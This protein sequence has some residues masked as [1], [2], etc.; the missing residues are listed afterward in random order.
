MANQ[1]TTRA[2]RRNTYDLGL[3]YCALLVMLL[4]LPLGNVIRNLN[5]SLIFQG[6]R[7]VVYIL[8]V[9][10]ITVYI[11]LTRKQNKFILFF[12]ILLYLLF[13]LHFVLSNYPFLTTL[14]FRDTIKYINILPIAYYFA[15][16]SPSSINKLI[17]VFYKVLVLTAVI[18]IILYFCDLDYVVRSIALKSGV[19]EKGPDYKLIGDFVIRR[20]DPYFG[21]G[22]SGLGIMMALAIVIYYSKITTHRKIG[23]FD[24][25]GFLVVCFTFFGAMSFSGLIALM[26]GV[27][28]VQR[29][30]VLTPKT[31]AWIIPLIVG[32]YLLNVD[33]GIQQADGNVDL[34]AYLKTFF[35]RYEWVIRQLF[36]SPI[37]LLIG[38]GPGIVGNKLTSGL[39]LQV[40]NAPIILG[41]VDGGVFEFGQQFGLP[42]FVFYGVLVIGLFARTRRVFLHTNAYEAKVLA[43]MFLVCLLQVHVPPWIRPGFDVV[44]WMLMGLVAGYLDRV[45]SLPLL[46]PTTHR[47]TVIP[48]FKS[49][50]QRLRQMATSS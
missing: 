4:T 44:F 46:S 42:H 22:P 6:W 29:S 20:M 25:V 24:H 43:I 10:P 14:G 27:L 1:T 15:R 17:N 32:I 28:F 8:L 33:L 39:D 19:I 50:D 9:S 31:L 34:L 12:F 45:Y 23:L 37:N 41:G 30:F 11:L 26:V 35:G 47:E 49:G 7:E 38:I 36:G 13:F 2:I 5:S 21:G 3:A 40:S 16:S 48:S 18:Q